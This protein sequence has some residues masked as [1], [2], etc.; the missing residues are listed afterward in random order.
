MTQMDLEGCVLSGLRQ[1]KT[2]GFQP[3]GEFKKQD[4]QKQQKEMD[5]Y[6][7]QRHGPWV[8]G[9]GKMGEGEGRG[10]AGGGAMSRS[11]GKSAALVSAANGPCHPAETHVMPWVSTPQ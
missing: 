1:P 4:R 6:R 9:A 10:G 2:N 11:Q 7:E 8:R 5:R 3:H